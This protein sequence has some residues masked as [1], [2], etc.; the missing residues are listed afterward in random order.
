MTT[1]FVGLFAVGLL[2]VE[3]NRIKRVTRLPR[4]EFKDVP[5]ELAR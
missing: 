3:G 5:A 1:V 4:L 2:K